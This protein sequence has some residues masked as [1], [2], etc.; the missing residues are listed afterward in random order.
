MRR[1]RCRRVPRREIAVLLV[2]R[3]SDDGAVGRTEARAM[4][5]APA[6]F[7]RTSA[8]LQPPAAYG[9][10]GREQE[11]PSAVLRNSCTIRLPI[12]QIL[13][14]GNYSRPN[15]G[16]GALGVPCTFLGHDRLFLI[17]I[18][19]QFSK[20]VHINPAL[21]VYTCQDGDCNLFATIFLHGGLLTKINRNH[22]RF[23]ICRNRI[24]NY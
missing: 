17:L 11:A 10:V 19:V 8:R 20:S 9:M 5:A 1:P 18:G 12:G 2:N 15:P 6:C 24:R 4:A 13:S 3:S 22:C 16:G 7:R 21:P 14:T 23:V